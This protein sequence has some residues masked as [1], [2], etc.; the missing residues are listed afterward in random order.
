MV[1]ASG[2]AAPNS[3]CSQNKQCHQSLSL[4]V[5]CG[6]SGTAI[7]PVLVRSVS[8]K[9][10]G[11]SSNS[12][13]WQNDVLPNYLQNKLLYKGFLSIRC[14]FSP[15]ADVPADACV[16][17]GCPC[18]VTMILLPSSAWGAAVP[19]PA[20]R[21]QHGTGNVQE[22]VS[23]SPHAHPGADRSGKASGSQAWEQKDRSLDWLV[24]ELITL[25]LLNLDPQECGFVPLLPQFWCLMS[26]ACQHCALS[27]YCCIAVY[28][29]YSSSTYLKAVLRN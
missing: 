4:A 15:P 19:T 29:T 23:A 6:E 10:V 5:G 3:C 27:Q 8:R 11:F 12:A 9:M 1:G 20:C 26:S 21:W 16:A 28:V 22:L 17:S 18:S 13:S 14:P 2:V 25:Q 7:Q 24:F